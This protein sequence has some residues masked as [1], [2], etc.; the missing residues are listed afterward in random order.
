M[1]TIYLSREFPTPKHQKL[2]PNYIGGGKC[3]S[4]CTLYLKNQLFGGQRGYMKGGVR[5]YFTQEKN[6]N[7]FQK[8][9]SNRKQFFLV[10]KSQ[11]IFKKHHTNSQFHYNL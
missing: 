6:L 7:L 8:P 11:I 2:Y 9:Y 3:L 1:K 5:V 4:N 10:N